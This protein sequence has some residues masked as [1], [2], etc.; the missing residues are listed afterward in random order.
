VSE[1]RLVW[2]EALDCHTYYVVR[3]PAGRQAMTY[4]TYLC[5]GVKLA[6]RTIFRGDL[7]GTHKLLFVYARNLVGEGADYIVGDGFGFL[8]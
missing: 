3:L 8:G 2:A 1:A 7:L 6:M 4:Y 5:S